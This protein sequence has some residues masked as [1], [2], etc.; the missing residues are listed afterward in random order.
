M[1]GP[2]KELAN[3]RAIL[4]ERERDRH[5]PELFQ[6]TDQIPYAVDINPRK[7]GL[8]L[9]GTAQQIV[10]PEFI[11]KY[12]PTTIIIMNSIYRSEIEREVTRLGIKAR[13]ICA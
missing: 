12:D 3:E 2:D 4:W 13:Y 8:Y 5:V 6:I 7:A 11:A 10:G 1:A 9:P